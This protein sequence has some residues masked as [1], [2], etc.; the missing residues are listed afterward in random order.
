MEKQPPTQTSRTMRMAAV[1][2]LAQR[3]FAA[4]H[5]MMALR[6]STT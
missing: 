6:M 1:H 4:D 3:G 2:H 5:V